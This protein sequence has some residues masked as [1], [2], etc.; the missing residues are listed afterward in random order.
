MNSI[1]ESLSNSNR[2]SDSSDLSAFTYNYSFSA[3]AFPNTFA[4][5]RPKKSLYYATAY[6]RSMRTSWT[7]A[8]EIPNQENLFLFFS[9]ARNHLKIRPEVI[10]SKGLD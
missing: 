10:D 3:Y 6:L 5:C 4:N 7:M 9:R 1:A 8:A 2:A